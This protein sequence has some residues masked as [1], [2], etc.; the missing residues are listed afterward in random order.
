MPMCL[1]RVLL[2]LDLSARARSRSHR[3]RADVCE[4]NTV[5]GC[6]YESYVQYV[7]TY[8]KIGMKI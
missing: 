5:G 8:E 2:G 7:S 1:S 3:S 4:L 6:K